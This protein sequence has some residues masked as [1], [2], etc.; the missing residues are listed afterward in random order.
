MRGYIFC[1]AESALEALKR[2]LQGRSGMGQD[3]VS[4]I[5]EV[6]DKIFM[7]EE[8]RNNLRS[9][10]HSLKLALEVSFII[11][12]QLYHVVVV[13][14]MNCIWC[15]FCFFLFSGKRISASF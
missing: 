8:E 2:A 4:M 3:Y 5:G 11:P 15:V 10:N 1:R 12:S 14:V 7:S 9:Q 13:V 6:E